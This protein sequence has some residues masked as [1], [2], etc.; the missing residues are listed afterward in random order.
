M[1]LREFIFSK[2]YENNHK[3]INFLG[4]KFKIRRKKQDKKIK[5]QSFDEVFSIIQAL[6]NIVNYINNQIVK[7]C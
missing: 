7:I 4:I 6:E 2:K 3:V 1:K 5:M